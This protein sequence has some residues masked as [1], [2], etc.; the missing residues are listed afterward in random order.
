MTRSSTTPV[1]PSMTYAANVTGKR[2]C[3]GSRDAAPD[4]MSTIQQR[5]GFAQ[6]YGVAVD[7]GFGVGGGD[8]TAPLALVLVISTST[9]WD[10]DPKPMKC[11]ASEIAMVLAWS[12]VMAGCS[13]VGGTV[14]RRCPPEPRRR[15]GNRFGLS[16]DGGERGVG[17]E[18]PAAGP[19]AAS[20]MATSPAWSVRTR[21]CDEARERRHQHGRGRARRGSAT[22]STTRSHPA[23]F[24]FRTSS[25]IV[26]R[27]A[28]PGTGGGSGPTHCE[29]FVEGAQLWAG[30]VAIAVSLLVMVPATLS[31]SRR[32]RGSR[33]R[34]V[35]VAALFVAAIVVVLAGLLLVGLDPRTPASATG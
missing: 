2:A 4:V 6:G 5:H 7:G 28:S 10:G 19:Q 17:V 33:R 15:P 22:D 3:T 25:P 8:S 12:A 18:E 26:E 30:L 1:R 16:K 13:P 34:Q 11:A 21:A 32:S 20:H 9:A 24:T 29:G 27:T 31:V 35:V 23:R 14:I